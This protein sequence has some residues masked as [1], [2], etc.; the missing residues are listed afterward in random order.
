MDGLQIR[1]I[2]M[3]FNALMIVFFY[4]FMF[5]VFFRKKDPIMPIHLVTKDD[6]KPK[7]R[8]VVNRLSLDHYGVIVRTFRVRTVQQ[9]PEH[10]ETTHTPAPPVARPALNVTM[11]IYNPQNPEKSRFWVQQGMQME[12][13]GVGEEIQGARVKSIERIAKKID[14]PRQEVEYRIHLEKNN[15]PQLVTFS[16]WEPAE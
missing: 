14:G 3:G 12:I 2:L 11:V 9:Q 4:I 13:V 15:R 6:L 16:S 1:K 5:Q 8:T 7:T 10:V